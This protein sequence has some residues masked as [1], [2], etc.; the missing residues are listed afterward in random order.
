MAEP[1][2]PTPAFPFGLAALSRLD[3]R[4]KLMAMAMTALA[5][6]I[7]IG[8]WLW[9]KEPPYGVLFSNLSDQDGGQIVAAL[10]QQNIPYKISEGGGAI[11]VPV[12]QVHEARLKLASQ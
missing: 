4:Q 11:L 6:A 1:A 7:L 9:T 3:A 2:T 12:G 5:I 8:A 10:Q